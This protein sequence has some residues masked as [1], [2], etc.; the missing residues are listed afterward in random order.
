MAAKRGKQA[1]RGGGVPAWALFGIGVVVGAAAMGY[2]VKRDWV[3]S[4]R[5]H[6]LPMPNPE[7][8]PA[9]PGD[10]GIADGGSTKAKPNFDFYQVLPEKEVVIPD[11]ELSAKA[12]AEALAKAQQAPGSVA[13]ASSAAGRYLLQ[14]GSFP[15]A[16]QA[17]ATKAKLAL[18]GFVANVQPVVIK[19]ETWYRVRLGPYRDAGNLEKVKQQLTGAGIPAIALKEKN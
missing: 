16:D 3:P 2:A 8:K 6:E 19:G 10:S 11:A 5:T 1:V 17:D 7:A 15:S 18:Q 13:P 12:K 9:G 4:L 14:V